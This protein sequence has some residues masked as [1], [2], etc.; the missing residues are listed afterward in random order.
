MYWNTF[1]GFKTHHHPQ[2]FLKKHSLIYGHLKKR[3][4]QVFLTL[5]SG[6]PEM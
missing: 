2:P 3:F 6:N 1:T 5:D 4:E